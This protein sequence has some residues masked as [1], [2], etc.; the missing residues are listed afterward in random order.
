MTMRLIDAD[1]LVQKRAHA[2]KYSPDMYVIGQGYV[3]DAPTIDAQKEIDALRAEIDARRLAYETLDMQVEVMCA[4]NEMGAKNAEETISTLRAELAKE[5]G[6]SKRYIAM[7]QDKSRTIR[8]LE[9]ELAA[10][11]SELAR[12]P[13]VHAKS[14]ANYQKCFQLAYDG[15]G[16]LPCAGCK[17]YE[18]CEAAKGE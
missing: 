9:A 11:K 6:K 4:E 3:M 2:K 13:W 14:C 18:F 5:K 10:A 16:M 7:C 12:V 8:E 1:A 17:R 15:S